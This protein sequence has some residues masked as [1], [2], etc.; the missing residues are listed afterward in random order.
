MTAKNCQNTPKILFLAATAMEANAVKKAFG[1]LYPIVT[2]GI[3]GIATITSTLKAISEHNPQLVVMV[4]IAGAIASDIA[5]G[6]VVIV[7]SDYTADLG[8]WREG[9]QTFVPFSSKKYFSDFKFPNFRTVTSQSVN[10][11]TSSLI[12]P[13]AE[14]ENME[15]AYFFAAAEISDTKA[16]QLRAISNRVSDKRS[17]WKIDEALN[18]LT[19]ALKIIFQ[20]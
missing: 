9:E 17:D 19:E 20:H 15:G 7:E 13:S 3:G 16:I 8:A 11:A 12:P 10:T 1:T 18:S 2:T 6:E 14:V 5:V 4:G